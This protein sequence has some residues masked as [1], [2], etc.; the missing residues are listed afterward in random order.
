MVV[1]DIHRAKCALFRAQVLTAQHS[2]PE[3]V[4]SWRDH[5]APTPKN[6]IRGHPH[7]PEPPQGTLGEIS[8]LAAMPLPPICAPSPLPFT[9]T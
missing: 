1:K 7:G 6:P 8:G 2:L 5:D 9:L 4:A 3:N